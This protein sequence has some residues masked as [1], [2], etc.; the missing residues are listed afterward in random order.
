MKENKPFQSNEDYWKNP[1]PVEVVTDETER[2]NIEK[3]VKE[4]AAKVVYDEF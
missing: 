1:K 4:N 3:R 2:A